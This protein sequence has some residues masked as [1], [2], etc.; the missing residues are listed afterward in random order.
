MKP[1]LIE[2]GERY[3]DDSGWERRVTVDKHL[4]EFKI[5]LSGSELHGHPRELQ[6]LI[7]ALQAAHSAVYEKTT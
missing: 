6:W 5:E 1:N 2:F 4:L 7:E 3:A